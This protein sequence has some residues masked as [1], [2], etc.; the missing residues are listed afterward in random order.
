MQVCRE[1]FASATH[2]FSKTLLGGSA[3]ADGKVGDILKFTWDSLVLEAKVTGVSSFAET[4]IPTE[5]YAA[6]IKPLQNGDKTVNGKAIA[7][8]V[9]VNCE[10]GY[11]SSEVLLSFKA[12][13]RSRQNYGYYT[14]EYNKSVLGDLK[15]R[16]NFTLLLVD[17]KLYE[18]IYMY[19]QFLLY[20]TESNTRMIA[21]GKGYNV[22]YSKEE[23]LEKID[24]TLPL[25]VPI[26]AIEE[27]AAF[28]DE[29]YALGIMVLPL[30]VDKME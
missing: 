26:S 27:G 3:L 21:G 29:D 14:V 5:A 24:K 15:A 6:A 16:D 2:G 8:E 12:A 17:K 18:S 10:N 1:D 20:D 23:L 28:T 7:P 11:E 25:T 19:P 4:Q 9:S 13:E 22:A 30:H